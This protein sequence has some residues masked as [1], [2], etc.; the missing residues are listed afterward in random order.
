MPC[1]F[2]GSIEN[3]EDAHIKDEIVLLSEGLNK[4]SAR[5]N[6]IIPLCIFHHRN[7]FDRKNPNGVVEVNREDQFEPTL[8]IDFINE[9]LI[10]YEPRNDNGTVGGLYRSIE[11]V[12]RFRHANFTADTEYIRWKN[13]RAHPR[14]Q[15]YFFIEKL[16]N[17]LTLL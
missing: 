3:V 8:A 6:N 17:E 10:L 5:Q 4:V 1:A 16:T 7:C 2:C 12:P 9:V 11:T 14:L 15:F 13:T